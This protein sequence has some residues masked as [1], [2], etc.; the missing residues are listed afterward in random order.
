MAARRIG[1]ELSA[2]DRI[3]TAANARC[4]ETIML[5]EGA[6]RGGSRKLLGRD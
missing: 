1:V 6:G 3:A 2:A 4:Q 5:R